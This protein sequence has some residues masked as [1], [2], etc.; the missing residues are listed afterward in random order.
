[1]SNRSRKKLFLA[2]ETLHALTSAQIARVIGGIVEP[3]VIRNPPRHSE[4]PSCGIVCLPP[5]IRGEP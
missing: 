1:M 4:T 5:E 2:S 3:T